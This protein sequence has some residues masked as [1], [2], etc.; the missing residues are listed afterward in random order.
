M[1]AKNLAFPNIIRNFA[2]NSGSADVLV[3][4]L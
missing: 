1:G 2:A 4:M 3:R